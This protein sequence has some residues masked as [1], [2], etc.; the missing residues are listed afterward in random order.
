[1]NGI[2]YKFRLRSL[3]GKN[4]LNY[5]NRK[6]VLS[7]ASALSSLK[8]FGFCPGKP[9][10]FNDD[11]AEIL[12]KN[13]VKFF[14]VSGEKDFYLERQKQMTAVFD[15]TKIPYQFKIIPGMGHSFPEEYP[16]YLKNA[17][18]FILSN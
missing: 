14:I 9:K 3:N 12:K 15:K 10:A 18:H 6:I 16:A 2:I 1:V 8:A 4:Y 13:G 5:T 17:L 7:A 11:K